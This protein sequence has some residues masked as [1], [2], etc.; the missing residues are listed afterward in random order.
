MINR[1]SSNKLGFPPTKS[2]LWIR[3]ALLVVFAFVLYGNTLGHQFTQDDAIVI[4]DNIYTQKGF[5][6]ITDILTTDTFSGFFQDQNKSNLVS[7]GRYRPLTLIFFAVLWQ[8]F[9]ATTWIYHLASVLSF[10][11]LGLV[12]HKL[13]SLLFDEEHSASLLDKS[14]LISLLFLAHP[15]HTEVVANVKGMDETFCLLFVL[16][17]LLYTFM[18][19]LD[20]SQ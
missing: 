6:G 1:G 18:Y 10:T 14:F 12:L 16:T 15:I 9:G 7:G 4:Y 5:S 11:L 13:L 3:R 17:T 2:A 19:S 8:F 20:N